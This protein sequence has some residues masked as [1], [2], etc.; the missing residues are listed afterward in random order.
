MANDDI[1]YTCVPRPSRSRSVGF[2]SI[3][4]L[5]S[6]PSCLTACTRPGFVGIL[7]RALLHQSWRRRRHGH[8][9]TGRTRRLFAAVRVLRRILSAKVG[10]CERAHRERASG[11]MGQRIQTLAGHGARAQDQPVCTAKRDSLG[12]GRELLW[13]IGHPVG[14]KGQSAF[15]FRLG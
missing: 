2:F 13:Q 8:I 11:G 7:S 10:A 9:V 15:A 12:K 5:F 3:G 6:F 1:M 14:Q 4:C